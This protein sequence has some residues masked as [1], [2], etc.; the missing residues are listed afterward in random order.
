MKPFIGKA[1]WLPVV[2]GALLLLAAWRF[3]GC[4]ASTPDLASCFED[5]SLPLKVGSIVCT[6]CA[7]SGAG[8]QVSLIRAKYLVGLSYLDLKLY[9][10]G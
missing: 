9:S 8:V 4:S 7:A 6:A 10:S 5:G 1:L 2:D 3:Q